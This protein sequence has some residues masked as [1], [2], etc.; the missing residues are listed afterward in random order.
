MNYNL[1]QAKLKYEGKVFDTINSGK[2]IVTEY[3][4]KYNI[5][6]KFLDTGFCTK[7]QA[8]RLNKGNVRDK[9]A[10]NVLGVGIT[11]LRDNVTSFHEYDIWYSMLRRC[12]CEKSLARQPHYVGCEVSDNFKYFDYFKE[13]CEN[14]I[15]SS[16]KDQNGENFPLDKD[17]LVKGN[18]TYSENTCCF[19][20]REINNLFVGEKTAGGLLRGVTKIKRRKSFK[21]RVNKN[22]KRVYVGAYLTLEEAFNAYKKVKEAYIKEMANK[23]K[24]QIDPRVYEALMKYEVEITD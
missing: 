24:D 1:M 2:L 22:G 15:G 19:V 9:L 7:T 18:K 20:P 16:S 8:P 21:V 6:V 17:I 11:G 5:F 14:Q 12:Y 23:W 13:W 4:D 3:I 10:T